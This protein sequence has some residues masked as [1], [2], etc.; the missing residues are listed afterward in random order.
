MTLSDR[1]VSYLRTIVPVLW[2]S[3]LGLALPSLPWLPP[4]VAQWLSGEVVVSVVTAATIAL[5][6]VVWRKVEAHVPDWLT[7][8]VLGSALTPTYGKHVDLTSPTSLPMGLDGLTDLE[9]LADADAAALDTTPGEYDGAGPPC[10]P[11][12]AAAVS[13]RHVSPQPSAATPAGNPTDPI[14]RTADHP[15]GAPPWP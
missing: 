9:R 13:G 6:Y 14:T 4:A 10:T 12:R 11:A 5:W 7:A 15:E 8:I 1:A 2:G 3:L